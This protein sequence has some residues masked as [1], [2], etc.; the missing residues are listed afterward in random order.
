METQD[1]DLERSELALDAE[2]MFLNVGPA[3]P[4]MHGTV[5]CVMELSGESILKVDVQV[6]YLHRGFEKMCERGTWTQVYPYIDRC[7]YVSPML[8]NVGFSLA[9]EKMLGIQIPERGQ[10][11]RMALGE[12]ARIS[13][14]LTCDGARAR[15]LGPV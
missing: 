15:E 8:N 5:R 2:P 1:L 3:H 13:D 11:Y 7:N 14:H 10:W 4:A 12:L 6:G 9:C